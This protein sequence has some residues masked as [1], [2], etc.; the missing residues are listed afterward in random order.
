[1][2][3]KS[4]RKNSEL[5]YDDLRTLAYDKDATIHFVG[6]GGVSMYSLARL[7]IKC[8]ATVSGSDRG[9]NERLQELIMLGARVSVGH[10]ADNVK[11]ASLVVYTHAVFDDNVE[12]QAAQ[13]EGIPTVSRA[14]YMAA[15]MLDYSWRIGVSG[16]HGKSTTVAMLE[17]IFTR[18]MRNPTVLS[19]ANLQG[20]SP[21]RMGSNSLLIYEACEYKD[22]FL[23]FT[24]DIAVGLNLELD[25]PDY[26][27]SIDALKSSFAKALGRARDFALICGDDSNL[28][29]IIPTIPCRVITFGSREVNDYRYSITAFLDCGFDFTISRFGSFIG[30]FRLNIPGAFNVHNATAAIAVALEQGIDLNDIKEAIAS[31][32]G[33]DGRLEYIGNRLG[34]P[35]YLD[36]AHHPTEIRSAIDAI[37]ML[38]GKPVTVVFKPHTFSRTEALWSEFIRALSLADYSVITDI[39]PA[40]EQPI[41]GICSERLAREIGGNARYCS[42]DEVINTIDHYTDGVIA[43]VGAGDFT[44]IKR[45]IIKIY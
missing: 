22:S 25:H 32:S 9:N 23:K 11:G 40:R 38:T 7:T 30:S 10:S 41:E 33:I 21:Y 34:R 43:L 16:S 4:R 28:T 24:P 2:N 19:G 20:G 26:F 15:L 45:E 1:M 37:R 39:F 6:V 13:E 8:G 3:K 12:L 35:I 27:S 44:K 31:F 36:Y 42:D 29:D 5:T 14:E 17:C 18:T